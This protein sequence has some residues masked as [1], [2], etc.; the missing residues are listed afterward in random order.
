[1]GEVGGPEPLSHPPNGLAGGWTAETRSHVFDLLREQDRR[2]S[3]QAAGVLR[4]LTTLVNERDRRYTERSSQQ[5]KAVVDALAAAEKAVNA[6]LVAADKAVEK[7]QLNAEKWRNNANE[8]RQAMN[9]RET[10]FLGKEEAMVMVSALSNRVVV[11]EQR[12]NLAQGHTVG[13]SEERT[14]SRLNM[15]AIVAVAMGVLY[16]VAIAVT[17]VIALTH[18]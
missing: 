2:Q 14:E 17:I 13:A 15:G 4:E 11:L 6:A 5:D 9:D 7:E 16:A 1:V 10:R 3:E 8:W 12:T 18:H